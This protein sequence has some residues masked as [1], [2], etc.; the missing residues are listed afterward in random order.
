MTIDVKICG[1]KTE[2][3]L[4]AALESGADYVGLVFHAAS[5]RNIDLARARRLAEKA[6][7]KAKI[8]ALLVDPDDRRL[9]DVVAAVD[10][11]V[12]QLHG[13]GDA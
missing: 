2:A 4:E 6:R 12:I 8:V 10:P 3:A 7:G 5:P 13:V 9:A 1:L 11:D